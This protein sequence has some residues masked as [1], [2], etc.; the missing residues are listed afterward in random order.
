[1]TKIQGWQIVATETDSPP[2]GMTTFELYSLEFCLGWLLAM[3]DRIKWRLLPIWEGDVE[4]PILIHSGGRDFGTHAPK[5]CPSFRDH[6]W[7][8]QKTRP[9]YRCTNCG[10]LKAYGEI[11]TF[12]QFDYKGRT[13]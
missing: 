7:F 1:M 10:W 5:A 9:L 2:E 4:E 11:V 8:E 6:I 12:V 3:D 13:S